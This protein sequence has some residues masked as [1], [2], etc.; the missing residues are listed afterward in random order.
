MVRLV[1]TD[2]GDPVHTGYHYMFG[3][4]LLLLPLCVAVSHL[5]VVESVQNISLEGVSFRR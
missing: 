5:S 3:L 1:A 2:I 4:L